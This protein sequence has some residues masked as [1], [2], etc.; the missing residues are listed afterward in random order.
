MLMFLQARRR[1]HTESSCSRS[2]SKHALRL[3][4]GGIDILARPKDPVLA[5]ISVRRD[6]PV[7]DGNSDDYIP[8]RADQTRTRS[9]PN[10]AQKY[11]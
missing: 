6:S 7:T 8:K 1:E 9:P 10:I 3:R 5:F 4:C 11:M 2:A